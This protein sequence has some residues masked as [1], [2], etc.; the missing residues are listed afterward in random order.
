MSPRSLWE[1]EDGFFFFFFW[2][3]QDLN[4]LRLDYC[5]RG[6]LLLLEGPPPPT[7]PATGAMSSRTSA[8][9]CP[10]PREKEL[11]GAASECGEPQE[12]SCLARNWGC[13]R[14]EKDVTTSPSGLVPFGGLELGHLPSVPSIPSSSLIAQTQANSLGQI[15][16]A[17]PTCWPR[18]HLQLPYLRLS[19]GCLAAPSSNMC[20][21]LTVLSPSPPHRWTLLSSSF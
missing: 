4:R 14:Q 19:S 18:C 15:E 11:S 10:A 5:P 13:P 1:E 9:S 7:S 3:H 6:L 17:L 12:P 20:P 21:F 16:L 8:L 2:T